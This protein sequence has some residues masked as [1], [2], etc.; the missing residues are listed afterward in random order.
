MGM[1]SAFVESFN[2]PIGPKAD[3]EELLYIS[4]LHQ[5][6]DEIRE[7]GSIRAADISLYLLSRHGIKISPEEVQRIL[8]TH[9][10]GTTSSTCSRKSAAEQNEKDNSDGHVECLD[11]IEIIAL[12]FIPTFCKMTISEENA[13]GLEK[14]SPQVLD[15]VLAMILHD[16]TI[17]FLYF[18][19]ECN[20]HCSLI[21]LTF[22]FVSLV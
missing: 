11:L 12:I 22:S 16:G 1:S 14:I 2:L 10:I 8:F 17:L 6:G 19:H 4:A 13:Q 15:R 18:F 20:S 5:T 9:I 7:N 21:V 3:E